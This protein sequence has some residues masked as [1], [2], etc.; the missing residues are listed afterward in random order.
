MEP[1]PANAIG[2]RLLGDSVE[3]LSDSEYADRPLRFIWGGR[4]LDIAEILGSWRGPSEKGFYI[5]TTEGLAF[6]LIY[7]EDPDD[8]QIRSL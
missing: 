6:E 4:R 2:E 3:C 1:R 5:K 7:R 8:W